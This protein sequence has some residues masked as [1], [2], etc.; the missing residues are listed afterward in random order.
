V[1]YVTIQITGDQSP[2]KGPYTAKTNEDGDY[3]IIILE[4]HKATP[5]QFEEIDGVEF[6]AEIVGG[7]NVK[8]EDTPD[9]EVSN[10]CDESGAIQI[11]EI[12][13]QRKEP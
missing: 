6:E 1:P 8:S 5:E 10:D 4:F 13:W 7:S 3:T 12:D 11:M 9:W 2:F